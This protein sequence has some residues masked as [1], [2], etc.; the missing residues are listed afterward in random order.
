MDTMF[1]KKRW[2]VLVV[3]VCLLTAPTL[4]SAQSSALTSEQQQVQVLLQ[5]IA[6]LTQI[7][8]RLQGVTLGVPDEVASCPLISRTLQL[9]V[10]GE[11]VRSLQHYLVTEK[12][13]PWGST[14]AYFGYETQAAVQKWQATHGVVSYGTPES[15]GYGVIGPLTRFAIARFCVKPPASALS[16]A[17]GTQTPDTGLADMETF[18]IS[19]ATVAL[20]QKTS[21][22]WLA[23]NVKSCTLLLVEDGGKEKVIFGGLN[24]RGTVVITPS[25][26]SIYIMR[27]P[28]LKDGYPFVERSLGVTVTGVPTPVNYSEYVFSAVPTKGYPPLAVTFVLPVNLTSSCLAGA[29]FMDFGD[30]THR[31]LTY[32]A[33]GCMPS[34]YTITHTYASDGVFNAVLYIGS[35]VN[36]EKAGEAKIIVGNVPESS[37]ASSSPAAEL[38]LALDDTSIETGNTSTVSWD[39]TNVKSCKL[40]STP[41]VY[42]SNQTSGLTTLQFLKPGTVT[43]TLSCTGEDD[44]P[45]SETATL[46][47]SQGA[48][49]NI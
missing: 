41:S 23:R 21:V 18:T 16:S 40:T 15:T 42:G 2:F 25:E 12:Y 11:D 3:A 37:S 38:T 9:G 13:L 45:Y 43:Y 29:Q 27:C 7:L 22:V 33:G 46:T 35:H 8:N 6:A 36:T 5:Q 26:T 31:A 48:Q 39:A 17:G 14:T 19:P 1:A 34:K 4:S 30:G 44:K 24:D 32:D 49:M 28:A 10:R 47:I 20:G